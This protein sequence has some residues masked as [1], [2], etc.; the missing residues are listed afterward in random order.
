ME[1]LNENP[2]TYS[3]QELRPETL[4]FDQDYQT[5]I[6]LISFPDI[7]LFN[8]NCS[9]KLIKQLLNNYSNI[10]TLALYGENELMINLCEALIDFGWNYNF[11]ISIRTKLNKKNE[12]S[13]NNETKSL[14]IFS[15]STKP[16]KINKIRLPYTY[17]PACHKTTKDY[18][19]KKHLFHEYGTLMSDVWKDF[20]VNQLD[21][22]PK[23]MTTRLFDMLVTQENTSV[24]SISLEN[25]DFNS[26]E[27]QQTLSNLVDS[28]KNSNAEN[29]INSIITGD[30]IEELKKIKSNSIDYIFTDPPY[31]IKKKY[32]SYTDDLTIEDYFNWCDMWLKECIRILKPGKFLTI[33]NLPLWCVRHY[34][35]LKNYSYLSSW[36]TWEALSR[37]VRNIMPANYTL[38]TVRKPGGSTK[39]N[40]PT[41]DDLLPEKDYYCSR[42]S[43]KNKR[44][45]QLKPLSDLWTDIHRVKHNSNRYNHP[46]QLPP[47]LLKRLISIYSER[48]DI[49]LDCFNGVGTTTLS[50][51]ILG[52]RYIGIELEKE[53]TEVTKERH[54]MILNGDNPF[55]KNDIPSN[56]KTKN[57]DEKRM[58]S[59]NDSTFTKK[60]I[61]LQ[62]KKL[63]KELGRM[64]SKE[65]AL[66]NLN[67]PEHIYDEKFKNWSEVLSAAKTTGIQEDQVNLFNWFEK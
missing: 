55:K 16:L 14:I 44:I 40:Y 24:T 47:L 30:S 63:S 50:A 7:S 35:F 2:I 52:R 21:F 29:K 46:T 36:T 28:T 66:N 1:H 9:I 18:G 4:K 10:E 22:L 8:K 19:G 3:Y 65:D 67:I 62:I 41:S 54:T 32:H 58:V 43:C 25:V 17:C 42:K 11:W 38:L 31:N 60:F 45:K 51:D 13:L 12:T 61:Q 59:K 48:D 49:V 37:P 5:N 34:S 23:N 27:S 53:Y 15:K 39:I 33:L 56:L 20:T 57:N 6:L 26:I 64:P